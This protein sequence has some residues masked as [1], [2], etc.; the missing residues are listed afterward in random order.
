MRSTQLCACGCGK[1]TTIA[2]FNS[3]RQGSKKGQPNKYFTGHGTR[4]KTDHL[5]TKINRKNE[6]AICS[7]CGPVQVYIDRSSGQLGRVRC[8][9][10]ILQ[11][12]KDYR[13]AHEEHCKKRIRSRTLWV[14]YH[15]TPEEQ[16]CILQFQNSH[17]TFSLLL[18]SRLATD[19]CHASGLIRGLLEWRVNRALGLFEKVGKEN[20][21][22]L[23]RAV[24]DYLDHPP[25]EQALNKKV[26]GLMGKA[27]YKKTM[28]YGPP[29]GHKE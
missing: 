28:L 27:K 19:H 13:K 2:E 16:D 5:L 1:R 23:L 18:G 9:A 6:I 21:P 17:P 3:T 14:K 25:A 26:Y 10:N 11:S 7:V 22:A 4:P 29:P 12:S 15:L 20:T 24:A 8:K